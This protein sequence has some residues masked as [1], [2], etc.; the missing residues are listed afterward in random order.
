MV[1]TPNHAKSRWITLNHAASYLLCLFPSRCIHEIFQWVQAQWGEN[2]C[3]GNTFI[4]PLWFLNFW[5]HD[6]GFLYQVSCNA[7][8][9]WSRGY[10]ICFHLKTLPIHMPSP[11]QYF[12]GM[13]HNWKENKQIVHKM[14]VR[15]YTHF[16]R[17]ACICC[18]LYLKSYLLCRNMG[19]DL[20]I[21]LIQT[22]FSLRQGTNSMAS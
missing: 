5:P 9:A 1:F 22:C 19:L 3:I 10:F 16:R 7:R 12:P 13:W 4:V 6:D 17:R 21:F 18:M 8:Q 20:S 14:Q 11:L 15:T 2:S